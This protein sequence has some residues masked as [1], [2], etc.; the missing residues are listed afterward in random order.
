MWASQATIAMLSL[1]ASLIS[2]QTAKVTP[3]GIA[4]QG[5]QWHNHAQTT[6]RLE[7]RTLLGLLIIDPKRLTNTRLN[8]NINRQGDPGDDRGGSYES[9]APVIKGFVSSL[10]SLTNS[11]LRAKQYTTASRSAATESNI[12]SRAPTC[13]KNCYQEYM[14]IIPK[15]IIYGQA[16]WIH[17]PSYTIAH[18]PIPHCPL[19]VLRST[20]KMWE[21]WY[22]L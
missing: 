15:I 7:S 6:T 3:F 20:S 11:I 8:A 19:W 16:P 22:R 18:S 10:T 4:N 2:I 21:I 5:Q 1:S 14:M 17:P 13:R 9:S 12:V